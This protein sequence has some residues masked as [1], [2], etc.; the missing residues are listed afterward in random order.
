MCRMRTVEDN[1]VVFI[2]TGV[3]AHIKWRGNCCV[4]T[5]APFRRTTS[6][7]LAHI[8]SLYHVKNEAKDAGLTGDALKEKAPGGILPCNPAV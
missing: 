3:P 1:L 8:N 2:M 5:V 4:A 7:A 6:E